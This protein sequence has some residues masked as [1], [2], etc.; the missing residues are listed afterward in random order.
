MEV[1]E[2]APDENVIE[3]PKNEGRDENGSTYNVEIC[4]V[5]NKKKPGGVLALISM[6]CAFVAL[7]GA[8]LNLLFGLVTVAATLILEIMPFIHAVCCLPALI[9]GI[10]AIILSRIAAKKGK[11]KKAK[12]G[13]IIGIVSTAILALSIIGMLI[14]GVIA[15]VLAILFGAIFAVIGVVFAE[16]LAFLVTLSPALAP[17]LA[18]VGLILAAFAEAAAPEIVEQIFEILGS[19]FNSGVIILPII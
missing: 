7:A 8:L 18:I 15:V 4:D 3:E 6:I 9:V 16:I 17:I 2:L 11:N 19:L 10:V 12:T 1:K 5:K 14:F 13:F